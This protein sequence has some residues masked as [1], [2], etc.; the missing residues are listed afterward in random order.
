MDAPKVEPAELMHM[1]RDQ[2]LALAS[3]ACSEVFSGFG[4]A[5]P[6]SI[7]EV[8]AEL[9]KSSASVGEH[10]AK[11]LEVGLLIPCGS[12]KR[13]SRVETL[14]IHAA[15]II[16]FVPQEHDWPTI[17][18]YLGRFRGQ[19]R[20]AEREYEAGQKATFDDPTFRGFMLYKWNRVYLSPQNAQRIRTAI[21]S[22]HDLILSLSEPPP[23]PNSNSDLVRATFTTM[24]LPGLRESRRRASE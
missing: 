1:N 18:A 3:M 12:R 22:L 24:L 10:V 7:R 19:M 13:R 14:F 11:L 16:R 8:S 23:A 17:E 6:H 21:E 15:R 9:G 5:E 2:V 20:L 4:A